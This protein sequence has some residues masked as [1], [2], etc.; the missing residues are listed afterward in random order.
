MKF[1]Y[2]S[3]YTVKVRVKVLVLIQASLASLL[4]TKTDTGEVNYKL[5]G[6]VIV[7]TDPVGI[8]SCV[9]IL[10]ESFVY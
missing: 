4:F 10:I 2:R 6:S 1:L 7:K 3:G 5:V 9:V 8:A